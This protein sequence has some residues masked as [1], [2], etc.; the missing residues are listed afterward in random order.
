MDICPVRKTLCPH[1]RVVHVTEIKDGK[2]TE[3]HLCHECE[4]AF[5]G[6]I[7]TP[8]KEPEVGNPVP[9]LIALMK[10]I[11]EKEPVVAPQPTYP[12]CPSCGT[13]TSDFIMTGKLGCAICFDHYQQGLLTVL[14]R[15]HQGATR[16][17]G[18]VPKRWEQEK[19][20]RLEKEEE[21]LDKQEKI[22]RLKEKMANAVKVEN[23][24]VAGILKK[25]IEELQQ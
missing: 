24:E 18:K 2:V 21:S 12:P 14:A 1:A 15:C 7:K 9:G 17:V 16:H 10:A 3:L 5:S 4:S 13:T 22:R 8:E 20:A 6:G 11:M 19:Q 23:Y 25:K